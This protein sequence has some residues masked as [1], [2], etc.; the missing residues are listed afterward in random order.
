M[1]YHLLKEKWNLSYRPKYVKF[2]QCYAKLDNWENYLLEKF[3]KKKTI[4]T[5]LANKFLEKLEA[6]IAQENQNNK[7]NIKLFV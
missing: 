5:F 7:E 3:S 1:I 6:K 4:D 2:F